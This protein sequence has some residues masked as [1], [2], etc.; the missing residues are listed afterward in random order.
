[1]KPLIIFCIQTN[2]LKFGEITLSK[3]SVWIC[4]RSGIYIEDLLINLLIIDKTVSVTGYIKNNRMLHWEISELIS[5]LKLITKKRKCPNKYAP[6]SPKKIL[7]KG[8]LNKIIPNRTE[9]KLN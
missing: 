1:M 7:G 5:K 2:F 6:L 9:Q 8:K 3:T 4:F